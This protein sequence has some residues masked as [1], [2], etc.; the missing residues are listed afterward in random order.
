MQPNSEIWSHCIEYA[1]VTDV[2]LRRTNNQDS[3]VVSLAPSQAVYERRGHLF[4]V[5][6]GMGAHAAGELASAIAVDTVP[7]AYQKH[8]ELPPDEALRRAIQA[9]ND[10]IYHRGCSN[11]DFRG[12]GTT[13]STLVI[14]PEGA[15]VGHVGDSRVYRL[16]GEM[17]EQLTFDHSLAWEMQAS[18]DREKQG[19]SDYV[20]KN[21]I[22]RSLGPNL[23][24]DIDL[25]GPLPGESGDTFLI[26]SDGL[27]GPVRD[28]EMGTII[29]CMPPE[30]AAQALVDL[31]NL[32]GGPD[33]I[34]V[35]IVRVKG[36]QVAKKPNKNKKP[37]QNSTDFS[38]NEPKWQNGWLAGGPVSPPQIQIP[39][40]LWLTTLIVG[41]FTVIA[42][43]F[44]WSNLGITTGLATLV[45]IVII[46]VMAIVQYVKKPQRSSTCH[47][48]GPYRAYL[49]RA[50]G[51]FVDRL[52]R[53]VDQLRDAAANE[54]WK[55]D[56]QYFNQVREDADA[57]MFRCSYCQA[58]RLYCHA[59]SFI[60]GQ[61]RHQEE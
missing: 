57:T 8:P 61:L 31:A 60:M 59:L 56:W 16:R 39:M 10:E 40:P 4:M 54:D 11:P 3:M 36:P 42:F 13:G 29:G 47:G 7:L 55:I 6:D 34:T 49:C 43:T 48:K 58:A 12:M 27:S 41:L 50:D 9:A 53:I 28:D 21:I 51:E 46:G 5:A 52:S 37:E 20:P 44:G 18:P 38:T 35:I 14:L 25:E 17:F 22:T 24:V 1:A 32:R 45:G 2:G 33:N 30:D 15:L 19:L 26:C 23:D